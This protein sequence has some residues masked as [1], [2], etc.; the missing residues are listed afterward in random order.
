MTKVE[1]EKIKK[2]K[3]W[4]VTFEDFY[5]RY[6]II[7]FP[8]FFI[9]I[10]SAVAVSGFKN[11]LTDL[12]FAALVIFIIGLFLTS[13]TAKR[14]YQNQVFEL[15]YFS[16]LTSEKIN[17]ALKKS[18]FENV[19]YYKLGY[20]QATTKVSWFSWGELITIILDNDKL[21][22][23]SR[24]TGSAILFQPITI[25]KDRENITKVIDELTWE[26]DNKSNI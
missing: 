16:Y 4:T 11:N 12:K 9:F 18:E 17:S 26:D 19:K 7:L 3:R 22:I 24:P 14:L 6:F 5:S 2:N 23:N 10:S 15:Y 8:L 20:F 21:L 13:F 25:F 1:L